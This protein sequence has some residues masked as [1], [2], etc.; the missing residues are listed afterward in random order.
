MAVEN[1]KEFII[2]YEMNKQKTKQQLTLTPAQQSY[3][4][5][6]LLWH[7]SSVYTSHLPGSSV[8]AHH[9]FTA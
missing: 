6:L 2:V 9:R 3:M 7:A 1:L 8:P 4:L 5:L